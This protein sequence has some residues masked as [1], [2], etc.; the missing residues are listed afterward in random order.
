MRGSFDDVAKMKHEQGGS[1]G[2]PPD[3]SPPQKR[4]SGLI[5][6]NLALLL[7]L[8][9]RMQGTWTEIT[10]L[11]EAM[12]LYKSA[13]FFDF[14]GVKRYAFTRLRRTAAEHEKPS[15]HNRERLGRYPSK[16]TGLFS[17]K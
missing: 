4:D 13:F 11:I 16:K 14:Y 9:L 7:F 6:N 15:P 8:G 5:K 1:E 10:F 17:E 12:S 2:F 3:D